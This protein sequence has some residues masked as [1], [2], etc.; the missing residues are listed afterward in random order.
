MS[1]RLSDQKP[2][3]KKVLQFLFV[4]LA[5]GSLKVYYS[6]ASV[7]GLC[8]ILWPTTRLTELVTGAQF[9]FESYAGYLSGDR[10]FL[11]AASCSGV[12]FLITAFVMLSFRKLWPDRRQGVSWGFL[13]AAA[14]LAYI[15]TIVAN[16]VRISSA[17]WLNASRPDIA[18]L[19]RDELH[20]LDGILIYFGSLLLLYAVTQ[21]GSHGNSRGGVKRYLLPLGVYYATTLGIPLVNG[22]FRRGGEFWEH[23]LFVL[24]VPIVLIATVASVSGLFRCY[25]ERKLFEPLTD[26][27]G[28]SMTFPRD[29]V[30]GRRR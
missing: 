24:L 28:S 20:R 21:R 6:A 27:D 22:A 17:M 29:L 5:A 19:G 2:G 4:L 8:W 14:V 3:I 9:E 10:T 13:P 11:I 23:A 30:S 26:G 18:G 25:R 7:E 15:A 16:A 12:N 1:M